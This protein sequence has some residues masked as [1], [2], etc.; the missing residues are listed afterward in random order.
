MN[1][2]LRSSTAVAVSVAVVVLS[3]VALVQAMGWTSA[4]VDAT[5]VDS[6]LFRRQLDA[7]LEELSAPHAAAPGSP[8]ALERAPQMA[9]LFV[10]EGVS[11]C[12]GSGCVAS[13]C[14]GSGCGSS[15]CG[16]SACPGSV[17]GGSACA[18][19]VCGGSACGGSICGGSA[20]G[21]SVCGGSACGV[22]GCA[23][24]LCTQSA[25]GGS[26]CGQSACAG[27]LCAN[28]PSSAP[29]GERTRR[30]AGTGAAAPVET[31]DF[32]P[33]TSGG[34]ARIVGLDA[35]R[36]GRGVEVM[37]IAAGAPVT[38]YRLLRTDAAS[39]TA[40]LIGSG[41]AHEER[42]VRVLDREPVAGASYL[43]ELRDDR[44]GRMVI[45]VEPS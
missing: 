5:A 17:C 36:T 20:C 19:S 34:A 21:G 44:D 39:P 45:P 30:G 6:P 12:I 4:T 11:A 1:L 28:C 18:G 42:I 31:A 40:R 41:V 43:L 2:R 25:C 26:L 14:G 9:L 32:C 27:S 38:S 15:A 35:R 10:S 37:W 13:A 24:S 8:G 3:G 33:L 16:G 7:K 23:G 22:S 29:A